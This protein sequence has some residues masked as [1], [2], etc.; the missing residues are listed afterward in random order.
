MLSVWCYCVSFILSSPCTVRSCV[1]SLCH[2][3]CRVA[4]NENEA[5]IRL[6]SAGHLSSY[7]FWA[8]QHVFSA[9]FVNKKARSDCLM[10]PGCHGNRVLVYRDDGERE[11]KKGA[12]EGL[13][14]GGR[15]VLC[16]WVRDRKMFFKNA[17][18]GFMCT[19]IFNSSPW[20]R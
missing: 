6:M 12:A 16:A 1:R 10:M 4:V 17:Q 8:R 19:Q 3:H 13:R 14:R 9:V 7:R 18:N 20:R 15:G 11:K 5:L 2:S